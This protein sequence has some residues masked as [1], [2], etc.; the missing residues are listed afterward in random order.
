MPT[1]PPSSP[2]AARLPQEIWSLI[3]S[4]PRAPDMHAQP[5][6]LRNNRFVLPAKLLHDTMQNVLDAH[7]G[8]TFEQAAI[9]GVS[10]RTF[11]GAFVDARADFYDTLSLN[12]IGR[13]GRQG[14]A[15]PPSLPPRAQ[16]HA[17]CFSSD[18]HV[19]LQRAK[20]FVIAD[21][22]MAYPECVL[23]LPYTRVEGIEL[24]VS[25]SGHLGWDRDRTRLLVNLGV[26]WAAMRCMKNL[27]TLEVDHTLNL[28]LHLFQRLGSIEHFIFNFSTAERCFNTEPT[29]GDIG[30]RHYNILRDDG[31][32]FTALAESWDPFGFK[33]A[34]MHFASPETFRK[35]MVLVHAAEGT[36]VRRLSIG[37]AAPGDVPY[38]NLF[39]VALDVFPNLTDLSFPR[40]QLLPLI[41]NLQHQIETHI[42]SNQSSELSQGSLKRLSEHFCVD[43]SQ[44]LRVTLDDEV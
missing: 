34:S 35:S 16:V 4:V 15:L 7:A 29:L 24:R 12:I 17:P 39:P 32:E 26:F 21:T 42:I 33:S 11:Y 14:A 19:A 38:T 5:R 28:G 40:S 3:F 44:H 31:P 25:D 18:E 36:H 6:H 43:K 10:A 2:A 30:Q 8:A 9:E 37:P 20:N 1:P 23:E 41:S 22:L 13:A 27:R